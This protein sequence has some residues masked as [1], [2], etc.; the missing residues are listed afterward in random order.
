MKIMTI[1]GAR[2]QFVKAAMI[3]REI[4][5]RP[6]IREILV[7]TGQ[8]YDDEMSNL[9]FKELEIRKPDYNLEVGS[10]SN[11]QQT[12][13]ILESLEPVLKKEA[14]N[15][16]LVYGDTNSTLAGALAASQ[17][18]IPLAHV[19]A[20]LRSFN[21][22]M[23]EEKNRIIADHLSNLL[24]APT[25]EAVNNLLREGI[26]G[27]KVQLVGDVMYDAAL[28]YSAKSD[29]KS[30]FLTK[31]GLKEKNYVLAT[32]HR[33]ENTDKLERLR[34]IFDAL[35]KISDNM[36]VVLPLHP[37]TKKMLQQGTLLDMVKQKLLVTAPVGY[38]DMV[39][40]TKNAALVI[41]DSGGLQKE[42]YFFKTP[43]LTLRDETE[44]V[45]LI[46]LGVNKLVGADTEKILEGF[47][48]IKQGLPMTKVM[49]GDGHASEHVVRYLINAN[50]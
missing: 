13:R 22:E 46:E 9:F 36:P 33:A 16:V 21:I 8:H 39:A 31:H 28:Y 41:T 38:L 29:Q 18:N 30:H 42:A 1:V 19:E 12:A 40:L 15:W 43:C 14:P 44:W 47:Y 25:K 5:S 48:G 50:S 26:N 6:G 10:A 3:S 45:E 2:P 4:E 23:P 35:R 37:R 20:G 27:D 32:V 34:G 49:Y 24:F 11:T 7:H 17:M